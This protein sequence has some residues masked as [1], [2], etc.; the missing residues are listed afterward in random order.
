MK[1]T[2]HFDENA[3]VDI[4]YHAHTGVVICGYV[5]I[6]TLHC[7]SDLHEEVR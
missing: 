7:G 5:T 4:L 6:L 1:G 3:S 2:G